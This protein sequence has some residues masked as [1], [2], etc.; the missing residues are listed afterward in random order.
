M[1][2]SRSLNAAFVEA[3]F[4]SRKDAKPQRSKRYS[5]FGAERH[6]KLALRLRRRAVASLRL[7]VFAGNQS[8]SQTHR[9]GHVSTLRGN[10]G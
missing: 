10:A 8:D 9:V 4:I 5:S 1:S 3:L 2:P 7:C 6:L